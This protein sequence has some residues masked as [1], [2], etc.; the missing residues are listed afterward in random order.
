LITEGFKLRWTP[1]AKANTYVPKLAAS[2]NLFQ[3]KVDE[4]IRRAVAVRAA[5]E[6]L[7]TCEYRRE[8]IGAALADI[9]T[10]VDEL[11]LGAFSN[12]PQWVAGVEARVEEALQRRLDAGLDAWLAS[13]GDNAADADKSGKKKAAASIDDNDDDDAAAQ[14]D[15]KMSEMQR[16][17]QRLAI[18]FATH[19][20]VI[21]NRQ[22]TLEPP[23]EAARASWLGQLHQ[24]LGIVCAQQRVRA[25]R[26]DEGMAGGARR[27]GAQQRVDDAKST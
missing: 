6:R 16:M 2:V 25:S 1:L 4:A 26:Y 8:T 20:V 7:V 14:G 19:E 9:Q 10:A 21:R 13:F 12:L 27:R 18:S 24:W 11:N 23:L 17:R 3:D 22:L 5:H 15:G